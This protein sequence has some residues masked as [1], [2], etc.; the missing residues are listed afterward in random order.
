MSTAPTN[1]VTFHWEFG[2]GGSLIGRALAEELGWKL[3]DHQLIVDLAQRLKLN[4]AEAK[5]YDEHTC[6]WAR[7]LMRSFFSGNPEGFSGPVPE[8]V[9][10]EDKV[11]AL[12]A[13]LICEAAEKGKVVIMGRGSQCVL[14]ERVDALHIFVYAPLEEKLSRL[15]EHIADRES[16]L[17][18]MR[19]QDRLRA[20]YM[21]TYYSHDWQ[22]HDLYH[23]FVDSSMGNDRVIAAI[24][25]AMR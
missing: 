14:S 2:S 12:T 6:S 11:A 7:R 10:D 16:A 25:S 17:R 5:L 13:V 4:V 1:V 8:G 20:Q 18:E 24:R 23:M 15:A 3:L 19:E 21:R 22:D 9:V